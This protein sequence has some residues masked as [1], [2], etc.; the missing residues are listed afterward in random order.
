MTSVFLVPSRLLYR[1]PHFCQSHHLCSVGP[2]I[3]ALT[4]SEDSGSKPFT[5][6]L[7]L[8]CVEEEQNVLLVAA[9]FK[10]VLKM[11]DSN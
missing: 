1:S 8:A 6:G 7:N 5:R 3:A 9:K 11:E 10:A 4:A 2:I